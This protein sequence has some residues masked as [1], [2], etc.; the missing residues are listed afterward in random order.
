MHFWKLNPN[1]N[2]SEDTHKLELKYGHLR[3]TDGIWNDFYKQK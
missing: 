1:T 3:H 2:L